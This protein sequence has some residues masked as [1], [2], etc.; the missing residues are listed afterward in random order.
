MPSLR[1]READRD[2]SRCPHDRNGHALDHPR[3][4][5]HF[6]GSFAQRLFECGARV[7]DVNRETAARRLGRFGRA[8]SAAALVG[9][10][11]QMVFAAWRG[12]TRL[13]PPA[14]NLGAPILRRSWVGAGELGVGDPTVEAPRWDVTRWRRAVGLSRGRLRR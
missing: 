1:T 12:E 6:L 10:R 4:R 5:D 3:R 7:R 13:E 11:K 14:Q 9:V 2:S 8:D